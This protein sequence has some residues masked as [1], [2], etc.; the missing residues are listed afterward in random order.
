MSNQSQNQ[1]TTPAATTAT[2]AS[3]APRKDYIP[4][5]GRELAQVL[6]GAFAK[7]LLG[8][9]W[10][11]EAVAYPGAKLEWAIRITPQPFEEG[12]VYQ[13]SGVLDLSNAPDAMRIL[14]GLPIWDKLKVQLDGMVQQVEQEVEPGEKLKKAAEKVAETAA[15]TTT[16]TGAQQP[17][18]RPTT[19]QSQRR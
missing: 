19:T 3:D 1:S 7:G 14:S 6:L 16:A 2:P 8:S 9:Q 15:T 18:E 10:M 12:A 5:S 4:L 11:G 17:K 13:D